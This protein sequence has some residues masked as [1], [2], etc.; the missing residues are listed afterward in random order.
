MVIDEMIKH[1]QVHLHNWEDVFVTTVKMITFS[2]YLVDKSY[3]L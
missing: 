3:I 1:F 2:F